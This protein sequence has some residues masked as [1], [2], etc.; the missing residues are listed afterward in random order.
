MPCVTWNEICEIHRVIYKTMWLHFCI[1][2]ILYATD[3]QLWSK[4]LFQFSYNKNLCLT[5]WT[6]LNL[7][8]LNPLPETVIRVAMYVAD[9]KSL[10]TQWRYIL[11]NKFGTNIFSIATTSNYFWSL[12]VGAVKVDYFDFSWKKME[13]LV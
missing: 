13:K 9:H 7:I 3:W 5:P 8:L 11:M 1:K 4:E 6:G 12:V 2:F 10:L